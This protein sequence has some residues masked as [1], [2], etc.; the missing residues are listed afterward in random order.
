MDTLTTDQYLIE[1]VITQIKRDLR[2][3]DLDA[4]EGLLRFLPKERLFGYLPEDN[5]TKGRE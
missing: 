1:A 4:L 2:N 3:K 5:I